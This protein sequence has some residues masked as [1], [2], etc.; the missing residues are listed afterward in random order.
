[1][2]LQKALKIAID[3]RSVKKAVNYLLSVDYF[4]SDRSLSRAIV[5]VALAWLWCQLGVGVGAE[6]AD[7]TRTQR[8]PGSRQPERVQNSPPRP[9]CSAHC[10]RH[11]GTLG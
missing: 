4:Q 3:K 9:S 6:A 5:C 2:L 7:R 11:Y 10:E 1:M 8:E